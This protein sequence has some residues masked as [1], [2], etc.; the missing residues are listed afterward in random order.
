M[1]NLRKASSFFSPRKPWYINWL[2]CD[3]KHSMAPALLP[4]LEVELAS[5]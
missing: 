5:A 3:L 4:E 2:I 1:K